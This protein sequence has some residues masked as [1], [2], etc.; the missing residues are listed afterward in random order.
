MTQSSGSARIAEALQELPHPDAYAVG[1]ELLGLLADLVDPDQLDEAIEQAL[2]RRSPYQP[3]AW[4]REG[5]ETP[6]E[7][8]TVGC[9]TYHSLIPGE[10]ECATW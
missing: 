5:T 3:V 2:G 4:H 1:T 9:S 6:C 8:G 7:K 10:S